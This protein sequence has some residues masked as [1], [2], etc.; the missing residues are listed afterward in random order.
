MITEYLKRIIEA[1]LP[2]YAK[3]I[4]NRQLTES[5]IKLFYIL[6]GY[7]VNYIIEEAEINLAQIVTEF[8]ERTK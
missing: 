3:K 5:E 1:K 8:M 7:K 4:R 6:Y 2:I